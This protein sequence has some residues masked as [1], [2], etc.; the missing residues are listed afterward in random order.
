MLES[1]RSITSLSVVA[2]KIIQLTSEKSIDSYFSQR[3]P[4]F[5][6]EKFKHELL[7]LKLHKELEIGYCVDVVDTNRI[8][9]ICNTMTPHEYSNAIRNSKLFLPNEKELKA[10]AQ[11]MLEDLDRK[12]KEVQSLRGHF[13]RTIEELCDAFANKAGIDR[14]RVILESH[15]I[16]WEKQSLVT[17]VFNQYRDIKQNPKEFDVENERKCLGIF[18]SFIPC[19]HTD[20]EDYELIQN[21]K[22]KVIDII[23]KAP[24]SQ[25]ISVERMQNAFNGFL[26]NGIPTKTVNNYIERIPF[27]IMEN[28]DPSNFHIAPVLF[29]IQKSLITE[30]ILRTENNIYFFNIGNGIF[31]KMNVRIN[32][33]NLEPDIALI[34]DRENSFFKLSTFIKGNNT[35]NMSG[36]WLINGIYLITNDLI[37]ETEFDASPFL[38]GE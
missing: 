7:A 26:Q 17:W 30:N 35:G 29:V 24:L 36:F 20:I 12:V 25:K 22:N 4:Y 2:E 37:F 14:E 33:D 1:N 13:F 6:G 21:Y 16:N 38:L 31:A 18:L 27:N 23:Y 19:L 15:N 28:K 32:S 8:K 3:H 9:G 34:R 11:K 10:D 5:D